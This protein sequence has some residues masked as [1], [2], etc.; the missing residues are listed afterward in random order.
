VLAPTAAVVDNV[1]LAERLGYQRVWLFDSPALHGDMW[2]ALARIAS[3]ASST[4]LAAPVRHPVDT[5]SDAG[6]ADV[7]VGLNVSTHV[8]DRPPEV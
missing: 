5:D 1:K 8:V 3:G 2:V 6:A 4:P 7:V